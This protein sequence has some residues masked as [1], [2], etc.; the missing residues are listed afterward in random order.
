MFDQLSPRY[1]DRPGGYTRIYKLGYRKGDSAEMAVIELVDRPE[2][3]APEASGA[4]RK[5]VERDEPAAA[6]TG[7]DAAEGESSEDSTSE[8]KN[9]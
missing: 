2:G 8:T 3:V 9:D 7:G 1:A 5:L 4:G 6:S